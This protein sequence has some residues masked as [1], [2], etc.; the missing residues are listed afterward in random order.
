MFA[1]VW[2]GLWL[3]SAGLL[4]LVLFMRSMPGKKEHLLHPPESW[5][6]LSTALNNLG[7]EQGP[8]GVNSL[9][10]EKNSFY[11]GSKYGPLVREG[12]NVM[13]PRI[14]GM[15]QM[16]QLCETGSSTPPMR[17]GWDC[18]VWRGSS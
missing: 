9:E 14:R 6:D 1:G 13:F 4:V 17:K 3:G 10:K 2:F 18:S 11:L 7:N 8:Q 15:A 16:S 5:G 12:N